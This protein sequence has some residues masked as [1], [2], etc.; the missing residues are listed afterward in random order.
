MTSLQGGACVG[1]GAGL[2]VGGV[3]CFSTVSLFVL[4]SYPFYKFHPTPSHQFL[5]VL[6]PDD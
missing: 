6:A 5:P 2:D 4:P 3:F 1:I